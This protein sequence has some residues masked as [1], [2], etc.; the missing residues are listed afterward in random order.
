MAP[1]ETALCGRYKPSTGRVIPRCFSQSMFWQWTS[2]ACT[3]RNGVQLGP[4]LADTESAD[5]LTPTV[6]NVASMKI[7]AASGPTLRNVP[8]AIDDPFTYAPSQVNIDQSR[9]YRCITR[10]FAAV[11]L[12]RQLGAAS[13]ESHARRLR[14]GVLCGFCRA[15]PPTETTRSRLSGHVRNLLQRVSSRG[16]AQVMTSMFAL[17]EIHRSRRE[18]HR[19]LL[20]T[21]SDCRSIHPL[22]LR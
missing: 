2:L 13:M 8:L 17:G 15:I 10:M 6:A 14:R 3:S 7:A 12:G 11:H 5:A 1:R 19:S 9:G 4:V 21:P 20:G 22:K 16:T 18:H